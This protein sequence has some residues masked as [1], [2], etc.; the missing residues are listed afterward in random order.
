MKPGVLQEPRLCS[1]VLQEALMSDIFLNT[2]S[3]QNTQSVNLS[4]KYNYRF[5]SHAAH[6]RAVVVIVCGAGGLFVVEGAG[7]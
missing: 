7:I 3:H 2:Q 6:Y 1:I 5:R 4:L